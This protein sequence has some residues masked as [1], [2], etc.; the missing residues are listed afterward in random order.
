MEQG[1]TAPRSIKRPPVDLRVPAV[2]TEL[3][4]E[5][6]RFKVFYGGRGGAKS[7]AFARMLIA[8]AHKKKLRILCARELQ[9]SIK[10]SVHRLL[11]DQIESMGLSGY[12][13][14]TQREIRHIKTGAEFLFK[15]LKHNISEIKSLEGID[16]TWV[17][18]AHNVSKTS[19]DLFLP[20]VLR[21]EDP[22]VWIS[23]NPSLDTDETYKRFV[24]QADARMLVRK[25]GWQDN[26]WFP[27]GLA[28]E[29]DQLCLKNQDDYLNVWEGHCKQALEGAVYARE[30][31]AAS[32]AG[33]I[34]KVP[35]DPAKPVHTFWDLGWSDSVAI[36][37]AQI[38]GFDYRVIDY[39][40]EN[41]RTLQDF[42]KIMQAKGYVYGTDFLPH[43]AA[44]KT[45]AAAGKSIE[46]QMRAA[47]RKVIVVPQSA[48]ASGI[49]AA[50][51]VFPLCYFD[52]EKC[53]DG[54][55]CLRHYRYDIDPDTGTWSKNPVHDIYSHGA[56]A[57]RTLAMSIREQKKPE[58]KV[59]KPRLMEVPLK[60]GN[61]LQR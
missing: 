41:Q 51:T 48:V 19:W 40:E 26:P 1:Q 9:T 52:E 17:E 16:I 54:L 10:D 18:E 5:K 32:L 3:Y 55:Q 60:K 7:W 4:T 27:K 59:P 20:T 13:D 36:W 25:V 22:E 31:R 39:H 12:F 35:Y 38:V 58:L 43:D 6:K 47:G 46:Q 8:L 2:F 34:T 45:L 42:I 28:E 61:W 11:S 15:G 23:F 33:R 30:L 53:A 21:T 14:V 56:D 49:N 37:F 44:S 50:R 24:L 57:F 29:K